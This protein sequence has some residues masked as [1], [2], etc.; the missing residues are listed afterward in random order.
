MNENREDRAATQAAAQATYD[1]CTKLLSSGNYPAVVTRTSRAIETIEQSEDAVQTVPGSLALLYGMRATG[2]QGFSGHR[3][4]E[5]LTRALEDVERALQHSSA[6]DSLP[7]DFVAYLQRTRTSIQTDLERGP[8]LS[9]GARFVIGYQRWYAILLCV[10]GGLILLG[11]VV[12]G[13]GVMAGGDETGACVLVPALAVAAA[14]GFVL[15]R[16]RHHS[17]TPDGPPKSG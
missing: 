12:V 3:D 6:A 16:Q 8:K 17:D 11:A 1:E 5:L 7:T 13:V 4:K 9:G 2:Y 15:Y 14:I 10:L